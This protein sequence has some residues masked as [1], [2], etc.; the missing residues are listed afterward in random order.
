MVTVA[1]TI[2]LHLIPRE[3][4]IQFPRRVLS[5]HA[6]PNTAKPKIYPGCKP[7]YRWDISNPETK[8]RSAT[9]AVSLLT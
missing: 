1:C 7:P 6:M 3:I 9:T 4:L 2:N 8:T 5:A